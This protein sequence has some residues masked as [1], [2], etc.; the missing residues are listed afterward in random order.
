M[1]NP[2]RAT[3]DSDR[4]L[5][6]A[7]L[8]DGDER[9]FRDLYRR[10][11]PRLLAFVA[12]LLGGTESDAED[13]VQD[14]WIRACQ[15]LERFRWDAAFSTWLL[16]IGFNVVRDHLRKSGRSKET[17][18]AEFPDPPGPAPADARDA[19]IDLERAIAT[20][21]DDFRLVLVLHDV[22]GMKHEEISERLKIPVGTTKSQLFRA[23]RMLRATL[24][25]STGDQ[26]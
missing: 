12:R 7:V 26:S 13:A 6:E 15:G 10:H 5:A 18:M 22:E 19:R 14:T 25:Q 20:L 23:R 2:Q 11:T 9:A 24:T 1:T 17:I 3:T 4:D 8:R 21:P 16:G